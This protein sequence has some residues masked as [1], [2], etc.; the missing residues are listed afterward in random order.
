MVCDPEQ[1]PVGDPDTYREVCGREP[2]EQ[3]D[4]R[5]T[6]LSRHGEID[7]YAYEAAEK[8]LSKHGDPQRAADEIR[9]LQAADL[10]DYPDLVDVLADYSY[11]FKKNPQLLNKFRKKVYNQIMTQAGE[12]G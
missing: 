9:N 10:E 2:P 11:E 12:L 6:Y 3:E 4:S 7:A 8:L 1:T 5:E